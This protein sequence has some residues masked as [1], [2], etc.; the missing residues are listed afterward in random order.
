[1]SGHC[2]VEGLALLIPQRPH[3]GQVA[4]QHLAQLP[5]QADRQRG[6]RAPKQFLGL[7]LAAELV[8]RVAQLLGFHRQQAGALDRPVQPVAAGLQL[9]A[10]GADVRRLDRAWGHFAQLLQ[11]LVDLRQLRLQGQHLGLCLVLLFGHLVTQLAQGLGRV[12][13]VLLVLQLVQRL[14]DGIDAR[15]RAGLGRPALGHG[16]KSW[17]QG[18]Q[19]G[20]Q[21]RPQPGEQA[22]IEGHD[23]WTTLHAGLRRRR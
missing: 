9:L 14:L 22:E 23:G 20:E 17:L 18:Q 15:L 19:Q 1:V 2:R 13:L 16:A 5:P 4:R 10:L 3:P 12:G 6:L 11:A 8:D 7:Q 21:G